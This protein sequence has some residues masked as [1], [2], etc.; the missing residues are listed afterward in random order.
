MTTKDGQTSVTALHPTCRVPLVNPKQ[1]TPNNCY[2]FLRRLAS[3]A[4]SRLLALSPPHLW[5]LIAS[6]STLFPEPSSSG[7]PYNCAGS[8]QSSLS[9]LS[10]SHLVNYAQ[11]KIAAVTQAERNWSFSV[12]RVEKDKTV[13]DTVSP[14]RE[15]WHILSV[16][17]QQLLTPQT[18]SKNVVT[19]CQ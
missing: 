13:D 1:K 15:Y 9:L 6:P 11:L 17:T 8:A 18:P 3:R 10:A 4:T 5:T 7:H 19:Y 16:K 12:W 2:I 14:E